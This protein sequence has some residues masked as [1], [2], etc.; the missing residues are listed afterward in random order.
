MSA[1]VW[2][3]ILAFLWA[4]LMGEFSV[5]SLVVGFVIGFL[6]LALV[7]RLTRPLD[8]IRKSY[9]LVRLAAF[10]AWDMFLSTLRVAH[11]VVTPRLRSRPGIVGFPLRAQS[12]EEITVLATLLSF[13]PGTLTVDISDDRKTLYVHVMFLDSRESFCKRISDQLEKSILEVL[14]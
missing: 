12:N 3:L 8:Y 4:V 10:F 7:H 9:A 5:A 2:N 14:R 6:A 11:D 1:L 13:T